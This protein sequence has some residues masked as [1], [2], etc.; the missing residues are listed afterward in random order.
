M[1]RPGYRDLEEVTAYCEPIYRFCAS[2]LG[3]AQAAEDLAQEILAEALEGLERHPVENLEAWIWTVARNR[4]RRLFRSPDRGRSTSSMDINDEP[5]HEERGSER[6]LILEE[7]KEQ[8]FRAVVGLAEKYRRV[9]V[10]YYIH[11]ET[12]E[13]LAARFSIPL[14]S[15]KWRI[16][17][18]RRRLRERW[19]SLMDEPR[20]VY[21]RIEWWIACNGSMDANRYLDRQ[22]ARAIALA[23]YDRPV[24]IEELSQTTG[25]P[26]VYIEDEL[27]E[28]LYGEALEQVGS[29]YATSFIILRLSDHRK[30]ME[31]FHPLAADLAS[32][33]LSRIRQREDAIRQLG[34]YGSDLPLEALLWI[35]VPRVVRSA[36]GTARTN[37]PE[38]K[39]ER[40]PPRKDG[41]Y[42]WFVVAEG[43]QD[44]HGDAGGQN[45]FSLANGWAQLDY[46]WILRYFSGRLNGVL[47]T[48]EN[49]AADAF[50]GRDGRIDATQDEP[51]AATM[52]ES[53]LALRRDDGIWLAVP[54]LTQRQ[55]ETLASLLNEV[56]ATVAPNLVALVEGVQDAF[57]GFTPPR[58]HEQ[59]KGVIGSHLNNAVGI[60]VGK[61]EEQG[62]MQKPRPEEVLAKS[63]VVTMTDSSG[64]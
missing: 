59:I 45:S 48:L 22:I 26:A 55:N 11:Q 5:D 46:Y 62:A 44:D 57:R 50:I 28:L 47:Q 52:I 49:R 15:V 42:G 1:P 10:G 29:K 32:A 25:I 33:V 6:R 21:D 14:S 60:V 23:A 4:L 40:Y 61:L 31:R 41:G 43:S 27:P 39:G 24:T 13:E 37:A 51:L 36:W 16:H 64:I 35:L 54:L 2:R 34:F 7:E 20:R 53:G 58:L 18:G 38:S 8:V 9:L 30:M 56:A 3:Y 63:V 17:E 12:Y 19:D